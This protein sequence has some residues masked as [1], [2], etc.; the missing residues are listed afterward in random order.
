M[1]QTERSITDPDDLL[2]AAARSQ[3]AK[4]LIAL[5][6]GC[7]WEYVDAHLASALLEALYRLPDE[8]GLR[9]EQD[10]VIARSI[11]RLLPD[12]PSNDPRR[13]E[14]HRGLAMRLRSG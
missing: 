1:A 12:I 14:I 10:R 3:D 5:F 11:A 13:R 8:G 6:L 9:R 4:R 7:P 2:A